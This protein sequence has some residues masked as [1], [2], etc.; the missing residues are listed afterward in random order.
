MVDFV[1]T[2]DSDLLAFGVKKVFFKMDRNGQGTLINMKNLKKVQGLENFDH[3]LFLTTCIFSGCDYLKSIKGI[4]FKK[5]T[6]FVN[7]AAGSLDM[8]LKKLRVDKYQVPVDY[9]NGFDRAF[10]TFQF[11]VVYCPL[12][13]KLKYLN[14]PEE[15]KHGPEFKEMKDTSFTGDL[16][17]S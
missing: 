2:E 17:S 5:A 9:L 3:D 11:Q 7:Q 4:G 8:I 16:S 10:H 6:K 12:E 14:D 15:S 13:K 1:I